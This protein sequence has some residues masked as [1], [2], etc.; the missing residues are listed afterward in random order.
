M[1]SFELT[2]DQEKLQQRL[3]VLAKE[4][5]Q[6][7]ALRLDKEK[8]GPIDGEFRKIM[9]EENLNAMIIPEA[10]GG[11]PLDHLTLAL[12]TEELG[13]GCAGFAGTFASTV[14]AV[15]TLLIGGS[16]E[17]KSEFLPLLLGPE[18]EVASFAMTEEKGGSD[19]SSFS[20][21]ARLDQEQYTLTGSKCPIINA[22]YAAFYIVWTSSYG[23]RGRAGI[24]ALVIQKNADGIT[25]GP[26]HDKPGLRCAPTATIFFNGVKVPESN[27]IGE[28]GSGYLLLT[29]TL[30]LGRA[31]FGA[32]SVGLA[33]AALEEMVDFAKTRAIR[34]RPI[35][36]NQGVSFVLAE[37][38]TELEAARLLVWKACRLMD[39]RQDY[40]RE[41]SMAKLLAS[42]VAVRATTEGTQLLGQKGY[43]EGSP[44]AKY[45]RDAQALRITEGTNHIQK[46]IIASQL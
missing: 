27:L 40:T 45:Q 14:H 33:R 30:D 46:S 34:G 7:H 41:S 35:I 6:P 9:A 42:E 22:G 26:F 20:T 11:N 25:Y 4:K 15:S 8:P 18:W 12:A 24:N 31:F 23:E 2:A 3:R 29:Q 38:A 17:L 10:F 44:M 13:Y 36:K 21:I 5:I 19:S 43:T 32:I 16:D 28:R 39:L 1:I 37:L